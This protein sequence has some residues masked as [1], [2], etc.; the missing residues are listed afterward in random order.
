MVSAENFV[1]ADPRWLNL[2][3]GFCWQLLRAFQEPP[4]ED[5]SQ[6]TYVCLFVCLFV[7]FGSFR[8]FVL[9][10]FLSIYILCIC[11]LCCFVL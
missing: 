2:T 3:L 1:N 5:G 7:C 11:L 8:L 10:L 4:S 9:Y 6:G